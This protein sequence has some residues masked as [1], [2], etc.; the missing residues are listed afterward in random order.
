MG[1]VPLYACHAQSY[2]LISQQPIRASV[3]P[4][5]LEGYGAFPQYAEYIMVHPNPG[6]PMQDFKPT[7]VPR[8]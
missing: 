4:V 5:T 8:L 1:E 3:G 6:P 2:L 7:G